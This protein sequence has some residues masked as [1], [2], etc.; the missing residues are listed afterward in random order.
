MGARD[1]EAVPAIETEVVDRAERLTWVRPEV[2]RLAAGSAE[3][4]AGSVADAGAFPS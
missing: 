3:D 2:R 4:G 1:E